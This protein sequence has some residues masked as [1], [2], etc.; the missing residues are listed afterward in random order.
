MP[1]EDL[2]FVKTKTKETALSSSRQH[3]KNPQQNLAKGELVAL[4]SLDKNKNIVI[5]KS[6]SSAIIDKDT[7]SKRME[8]FLSDQ[9]KF[10]KVTVQNDAF[11]N[12]VGNEEKR[13]DNVFK[14]VVNS[15]LM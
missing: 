3:N 4:K 15:K 9:R 13:T 11:L 12:F 8:N 10:E 5:Q 1:H 6:N 7:Y 2:D 14:N